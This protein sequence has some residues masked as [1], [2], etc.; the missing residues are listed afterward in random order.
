MAR[1]W[2]S[3]AT[4][5]QQSSSAP[6]SPAPR[7]NSSR[8]VK[9]HASGDNET[10]ENVN[11]YLPPSLNNRT[12]EQKAS[13]P[14][15]PRS[16]SRDATSAAKSA[17]EGT[18]ASEGVN[19][20]LFRSSEND[21][22]TFSSMSQDA[23]DW[24]QQMKLQQQQQHSSHISQN[25]IPRRSRMN[26]RDI[27]RSYSG[28]YTS[29]GDLLPFELNRHRGTETN[30]AWFLGVYLTLVAAVQLFSLTVCQ[31]MRT[32]WTVTNLI[33]LV[34]SLLYVHWI[35]GSL[36]DE[37]GEMNA[38]TVWEQLEATQGTKPVR[39]VLLIVP[40]VLTY[41]ACWSMNYQTRAS[42]WNIVIWLVAVLA[43]LPFMNGVRIFGINRTAGIDDDTCPTPTNAGAVAAAS[44]GNGVA[45]GFAANTTTTT[46][47]AADADAAAVMKKDE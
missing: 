17:S 27:P 18:C 41:T 16:A 6:S 43:K 11:L 44:G 37:Q 46:N 25:N 7:G 47:V 8:L 40:T 3:T 26:S 29:D 14:L 24:Q 21:D 12:P 23:G 10:D 20:N 38:L 5:Q 35:K 2:G 19:V 9:P 36:A 42:F 15:R 13:R 32:S 45:G 4:Q 28:L 1:L 34:F 31:D 33:H 39:Q 30:T 22:D